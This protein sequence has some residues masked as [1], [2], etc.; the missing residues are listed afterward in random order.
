MTWL[1]DSFVPPMSAPLALGYHLRPIRGADIHLDYPAVMGSQGR[2]WS[3]FG[4]RWDWPPPT[5][6]F[7]QDLEDLVR[8][9]REME[10]RSSFNYCILDDEESELFGCVYIDPPEEET[11][12]GVDA[13]VCWWVTD[14][15][16]STALASLVDDFVPRW[17]S[18]CWPLA[19]P[20]TGIWWQESI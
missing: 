5:L 7:A 10:S 4:A 8:H 6:T 14:V 13:E 11:P 16:A 20:R 19:N 17:I 18:D 15:A 2:L 12:E 1:P 9:E 3:L